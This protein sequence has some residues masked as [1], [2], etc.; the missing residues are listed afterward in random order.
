MCFK[1]MGMWGEIRACSFLS[2]T[3]QGSAMTENLKY[4][5]G[6]TAASIIFTIGSGCSFITFACLAFAM[7]ASVI[8]AMQYAILSSNQRIFMKCVRQGS[9]RQSSLHCKAFVAYN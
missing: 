4:I 9:R 1:A 3:L 6:T 8:T 2:D 7:R 5:A